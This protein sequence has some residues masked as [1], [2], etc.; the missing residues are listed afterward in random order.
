MNL[1]ADIALFYAPPFG[2][3]TILRPAAGGAPIT[4]RAILDRPGADPF[5]GSVATT[6]YVL[7]YPT[8]TFPQVAEGDRITVGGADYVVRGVPDAGQDG[9]EAT[10]PLAKL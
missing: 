1:A 2:L 7:R 8:A 9:L 6:D 5:S 3:E 4:G 10:V